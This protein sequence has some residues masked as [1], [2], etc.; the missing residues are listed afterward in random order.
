MI[1]DGSVAAC[2]MEISKDSEAAERHPGCQWI[3]SMDTIG[4]PVICDRRLANVDL[5]DAD[6]PNT[7]TRRMV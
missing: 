3:A 4:I 6:D 7:R 5:P 2:V 1:Q